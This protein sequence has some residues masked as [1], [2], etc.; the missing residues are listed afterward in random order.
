[1][2]AFSARLFSQV[3]L[4][5]LPA[6]KSDPVTTVSYKKKHS[7]RR[8]ALRAV[9]DVLSSLHH[10]GYLLAAADSIYGDTVN[11]FAVVNSGKKYRFASIRPGSVTVAGV[12]RRITSFSSAGSK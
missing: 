2:V 12:T 3:T 10:K 7:E 6:Q 11:V 5:V 4:H 9:N 8:H 1:M